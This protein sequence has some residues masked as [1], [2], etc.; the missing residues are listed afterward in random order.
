MVG[1]GA[2]MLIKRAVGEMHPELYEEALALFREQYHNNVCIHSTLY[3]SVKNVLT[4]FSSKIQTILTNKPVDMANLLIKKLQIDGFFRKVLGG[5]IG[6]AL[7]PNP[8]GIILLCREFGVAPNEAVMVGDSLTDIKAGQAAGVKTVAVTYGYR[9]K[10][11][12]EAAHPD[13]W[14]KHPNDLIKIVK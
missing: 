11:E 8:Q 12:L 5:S 1:D 3:P 6:L 7:K 2:T 4:H 9:T 10:S 13:F 14:L